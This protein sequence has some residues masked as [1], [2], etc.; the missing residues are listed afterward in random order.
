MTVTSECAVGV[1]AV[2]VVVT[3]VVITLV[4]VLAAV[5]T[6]KPLTTPGASYDGAARRVLIPA[7]ADFGAVVSP[8][9]DR[10]C[11]S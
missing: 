5:R 7:I 4:H 6:R 10:A 8:Q 3:R 1:G 2:G 9:T 11:C